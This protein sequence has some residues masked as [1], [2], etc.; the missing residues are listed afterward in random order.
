MYLR[1]FLSC[2]SA[3]ILRGFFSDI[4]CRNLG[5][6]VEVNNIVFVGVGSEGGGAY[7]RIPLE[8]LTLRVV[9]T[10]L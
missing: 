8:F 1:R 3:R 4:S 2:P 5:E 7:D 9:H 6:L 10:N